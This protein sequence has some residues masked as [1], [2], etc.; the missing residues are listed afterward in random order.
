M[1][2]EKEITPLTG[3]DTDVLPEGDFSLEE[4]LAEYG[5]G[6][7]RQLFQAPRTPETEPRKPRAP[8]RPAEE[9]EAPRVDQCSLL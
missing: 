9:P 3:M 4:I 8:K 5:G 7:E 6:L 1:A 2:N